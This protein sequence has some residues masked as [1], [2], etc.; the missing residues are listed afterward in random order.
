[1]Q[2]DGYELYIQLNLLF[3]NDYASPI[4]DKNNNSIGY[5]FKYERTIKDYSIYQINEQLKAMI[6]LYFN[7]AQLKN[8]ELCNWTL[9]HLLL[10]EIIY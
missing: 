6:K 1:M 2:N 9:L 10:K 3:N 5:A 8:N 7:H 4:F